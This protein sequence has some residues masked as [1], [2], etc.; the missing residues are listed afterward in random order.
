MPRRCW[1]EHPDPKESAGRCTLCRKYVK[2]PA[3]RAFC[4]GEHADFCA[5]E[6]VAVRYRFAVAGFGTW[7]VEYSGAPHCRWAHG[8]PGPQWTMVV[9]GSPLILAVYAVA[10]GMPTPVEYRIPCADWD[11]M[12]TTTLTRSLT[13]TACDG[14]PD[15]IDVEPV[16]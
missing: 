1:R 6:A 15:S 3:Y 5:K 14:W 8:G 7:T 12:A 16:P 10:D 9:G 13:G 11:P 4:D 2:D